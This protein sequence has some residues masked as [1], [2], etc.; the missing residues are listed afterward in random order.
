LLSQSV[1]QLAEF[2]ERRPHRRLCSREQI[3]ADSIVLDD[4]ETEL[5]VCFPPLLCP[6]AL[7]PPLALPPCVT[8]QDA[9]EAT[10]QDMS[11]HA[12]FYGSTGFTA[13]TLAIVWNTHKDGMSER[14][15][16]KQSVLIVHFFMVFVFMHT[17]PI[18]SSW[19]AHMA[20]IKFGRRHSY[21]KSI[22]WKHARQIVAYLAE[23]LDELELSARDDPYNHGTGEL[24]CGVKEI[25]DTFP[26]VILSRDTK[27]QNP[28][29]D[30]H[31]LKFQIMI[32][33]TGRI[34]RCSGAYAGR[35]HDAAIYD[36]EYDYSDHIVMGDKA[37]IGSYLCLTAKIGRQSHLQRLRQK[38]MNRF[39]VRVEHTI[40]FVKAHG[41]F[42]RPRQ[43][44]GRSSTLTFAEQMVG[45]VVHCK[46]IEIKNA[47]GRLEGIGPWEH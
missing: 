2:G 7:P 25:V 47:G 39:R 41:L 23:H 14:L 30:A 5:T 22:F 42:S 17:L 10:F 19:T 33:F 11:Q 43:W 46:S 28:K 45:I 20:F 26:L 13:V 36:R 40:G 16:V 34:T 24:A 9:T 44:G 21:N 37:Y 32:T 18:Y 15:G 4:G 12:N 8:P 3:S 1:A 38:H 29:Y 35:I 31:V 6:P 27:H